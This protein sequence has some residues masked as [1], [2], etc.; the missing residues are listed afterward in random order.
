MLHCALQ[1][2]RDKD[3]AERKRKAEIARLRK[4]KIMAQMSEMQ[5]HFIDENRELFQ[6]S[7]DELSVSASTSHD[8]RWDQHLLKIC[9]LDTPSLWMRRG[10]GLF[11]VYIAFR[12][13]S[14]GFCVQVLCDKRK[15]K[16]HQILNLNLAWAVYSGKG[17]APIDHVI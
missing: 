6:Q 9:L 11:T 16:K 8:H 17:N 1:S 2:T 12:F 13:S 10:L 4:E 14:A 15:Q 3:K 5:R 7:L